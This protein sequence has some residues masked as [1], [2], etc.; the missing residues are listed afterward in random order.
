MH[1]SFY[2]SIYVAYKDLVININVGTMNTCNECVGRLLAW[3][4]KIG[5][6]HKQEIYQPGA[7]LLHMKSGSSNNQLVY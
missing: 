6:N 5:L 1:F 3:F 2:F 4:R 7:I